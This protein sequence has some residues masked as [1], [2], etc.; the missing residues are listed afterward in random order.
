MLPT[1]ANCVGDSSVDI[2][3]ARIKYRHRVQQIRT[4]RRH[5]QRQARQHFRNG[6]IK[7]AQQCGQHDME[8]YRGLQVMQ[9]QFIRLQ[10][11]FR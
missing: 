11:S 3:R 8:A 2:R 7:A 4:N 9:M 10:E 5:L 1:P 6:E